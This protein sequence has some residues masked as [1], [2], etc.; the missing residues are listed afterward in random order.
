MWVSITG[1]TVMCF[2]DCHA[3]LADPRI[4]SRFGSIARTSR[5]DGVGGII[6]TAAHREE[7]PSISAMCTTEGIWGAIGLHP[8]FAAEWTDDIPQLL[9]AYVQSQPG[10]CAIGEIG[11]DFFTGRETAALQERV[12]QQQLMCAN[13]LG[14]PAV[15]HN[16]KSWPEFFHVL[17]SLE[18]E[19]KGVCHHF[20]GSIEIARHVLSRGLYLSFCGP[21]TRREARR[22][23]EAARFTP[24]NRILTESDCPDLAPDPFRS[25]ESRPWHVRY[26]VKAIAELKALPEWR[27][28]EAVAENFQQLFAVGRNCQVS[29]DGGNG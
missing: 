23:R 25:G 27:V 17:D 1:L 22:L 24:L 7:W 26:V 9:T 28:A 3:H 21:V 19:T 15:F 6:A 20:S 16:R 2:Y 10:I 5:H 4:R 12:F 29:V 8:F 18:G 13:I 14:L 11:L